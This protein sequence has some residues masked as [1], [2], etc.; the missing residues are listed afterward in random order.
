V[1]SKCVVRLLTKTL[2]V[3][4]AKTHQTLAKLSWRYVSGAPSPQKGLRLQP[5]VQKNGPG[6]HVTLPTCAPATSSEVKVE[7][8]FGYENSADAACV[9]CVNVLHSRGRERDRCGQQS[10][11]SLAGPRSKVPDGGHPTYLARER[12]GDLSAHFSSPRVLFLFLLLL[13]S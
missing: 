9:G 3:R 1:V 2:S 6:L 13:A 5:K 7:T 12:T 11:I 10:Y 4:P 8:V